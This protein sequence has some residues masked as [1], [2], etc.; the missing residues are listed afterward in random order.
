MT[1][2]TRKSD[3]KRII[4]KWWQKIL[5]ILGCTAFCVLAA[6]LLCEKILD[7]SYIDTVKATL[8][9][10]RDAMESMKSQNSE[11]LEDVLDI[12]AKLTTQL[13]DGGTGDA[14]YTGAVS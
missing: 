7:P 10:D 2:K 12:R 9:I 13:E 11:F 14:G 3:K 5:L 8:E 4:L 1:N 6:W